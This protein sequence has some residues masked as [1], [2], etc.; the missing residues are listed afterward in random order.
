MG[1]VKEVDSGKAKTDNFF[2]AN[3]TRINEM[4]MGSIIGPMVISTKV[5]SSMI[6]ETELAK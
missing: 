1:N 2:K 4:A 3:T 5:N 6:I